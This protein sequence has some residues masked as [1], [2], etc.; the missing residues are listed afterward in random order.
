[1]ETEPNTMN[2]LSAVSRPTTHGVSP[3][4]R[5]SRLALRQPQP[6]H[7]LLDAYKR[8]VT[9]PPPEVADWQACAGTQPSPR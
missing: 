5:A 9:L 8:K 3:L 7:F 2:G 1:M 4:G 6:A